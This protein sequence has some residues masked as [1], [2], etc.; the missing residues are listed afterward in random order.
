[1]CASTC[2][3]CVR[4][5]PSA[6]FVA[7]HLHRTAA[8]HLIRR[9]L[10]QHRVHRANVPAHARCCIRCTGAAVA[11][12]HASEVLAA[13]AA[14]C[15]MQ[16][17][18]LQC[19]WLPQSEA[20]HTHRMTVQLWLCRECHDGGVG[21]WC[22]ISLCKCCVVHETLGELDCLSCQCS[23]RVTARPYLA[24]ASTCAFQAHVHAS[25]CKCA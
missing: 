3:V 14:A 8:C 12:G 1:M 23:R 6:Q 17:R 24:H 15:S 11:S 19:I 9:Q 18:R 13:R 21:A 16:C 22:P 20:T 2:L 10:W 25:M 4:Q 5:T 7:Q